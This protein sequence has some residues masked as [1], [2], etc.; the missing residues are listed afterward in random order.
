MQDGHETGDLCPV[1][2]MIG[3]IAGLTLPVDNAVHT[4][5]DQ[6]EGTQHQ[7]VHTGDSFTGH[8]DPDLR[9]QDVVVDQC[10]TVPDFDEDIIAEHRTS[11]RQDP[12]RAV[13]VVH[14]VAGDPR[15]LRL[16]V[17]PDSHD[18]VVNIIAP[19]CH[20]DRCMQL[21]AGRLCA[22]QLL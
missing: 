14:Q 3:R 15:L 13:V 8:R 1:T 2:D 7:V 21:D 11:G 19:D 18:T 10:R 17:T 6:A 12:V 20:V 9:Q 16:P 22:A 4:R 5:I